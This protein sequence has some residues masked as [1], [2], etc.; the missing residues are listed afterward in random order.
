MNA[1]NF[2][3]AGAIIIVV[4]LVAIAARNIFAKSSSVNSATTVGTTNLGNN[5]GSG[6]AN[7]PDAVQDVKLSLVNYA[8]S[9]EPKILKKGIPVRMTVDLNTV[10]GCARSV[11]IPELGVRKNVGPGDNVIE[12]TPGRAGTFTIACSM[13]MYFGKISVTDDGQATSETVAAQ[14]Q[15]TSTPKKSGGCGCGMMKNSASSGSGTCGV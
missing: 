15:A 12:F 6:N 7:N 5:A 14:Q 4:V 9:A 3:I 10:V 11:T 8:Y 13:N 2:L 1:K